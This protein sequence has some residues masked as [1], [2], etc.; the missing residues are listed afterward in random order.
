MRG[1][2][3]KSAVMDW[4]DIQD[5]DE[6]LA[7]TLTM[8]QSSQFQRLDHQAA[9]QNLKHFLNK[10]NSH[11]FGNA[12]KRFDKR[13][14][15]LPI[16]EISNWQRLHYHLLI[17]V[18]QLTDPAKVAEIIPLL[19]METRFGYSEISVDPVYSKHW[20]GYITKKLS[21]TSEI[22]FENTFICCRT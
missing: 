16:L 18:P 3:Y 4:I 1:G 10:L 6:C 8:K 17:R 13:F 2:E 12:F 7:V 5:T 15:I 14:E 22:D 19:W 20:V 9:S 21:S 11:F